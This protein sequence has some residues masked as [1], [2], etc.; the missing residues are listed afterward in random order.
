MEPCLQSFYAQYWGVP[1]RRR[2]IHLAVDFRGER[3]AEILFERKGVRGYFETGRTPWQGS[4]ADAERGVGADD[5]AGETCG[6]AG[7]RGL[8]AVTLEPVVYDGANVTSPIN[9]SNSQPGDPCHTL[10]TDSR[11]YVVIPY[12]LKI[13]SGCEGGGK[14]AL[15]QEDKSA[16]LST[17]NDQY[18]FQPVPG[19]LLDDQ[20]G[21]QV[22]VRTDGKAP[23]LRA[24]MHGNVPCVMCY[25]SCG[26]DDDSQSRVVVLDEQQQ[27]CGQQGEQD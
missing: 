19:L 1:Q 14:G 7:G 27:Q 2:R 12:T 9:A 11:N 10:G 6:G 18:L 25:D 13:R 17:N 5:R 16:T 22:N 20:G 8:D 23:T 21:Q 24:E 4:A 26:N 3:A 15:I